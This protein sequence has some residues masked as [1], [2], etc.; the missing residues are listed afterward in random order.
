MFKAAATAFVKSL[1]A[2]KHLVPNE[3]QTTDVEL[4]TLVRIK[5]GSFWTHPSY[6]VLPYTLPKLVG[7]KQ[8]SPDDEEKEMAVDFKTYRTIGGDVQVKAGDVVDAGMSV[9]TVDAMSSTTI[10]KRKVNLDCVR[11]TFRGR[12]I[13]KNDLKQL[14]LNKNNK[15]AFVYARAYNTQ[16]VTLTNLGSCKGKA[17]ALYQ[18]LVNVGVGVRMET[19]TNYKVPENST[20]A[21]S[22]V[23]IELED[24]MIEIPFD[25][26]SHKRGWES[27]AIDSDILEKAREGIETKENILNLIDRLPES[28]RGDVL[29]QLR[30]V[31]EEEDALSELEDIL[32]DGSGPPVSKAVSSFLDILGQSKAKDGLRVLVAALD[33]LPLPLQRPLTS[34]SPETITVLHQLV[35]SLKDS[36]EPSLPGSVPAALQPDGDLRW[37]ADLLCSS[38]EVLKSLTD[39]FAVPPEVLLEVLALAVMGIHKLQGGE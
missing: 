1:N 16:P 19:G 6:K 32:D 39:L 9:D 3:D 35:D 2:D 11:E 14:K 7:E 26:W 23:E 24:G 17:S 15:L 36:D 38:D 37:A 29:K 28:I 20:F 12:V 8:F 34:G 10:K 30:E 31:L 22:L 27:D 4:L 33:A 18:S 25:T 13:K 21:Y 5:K